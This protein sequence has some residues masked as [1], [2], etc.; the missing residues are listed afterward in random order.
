MVKKRRL[1]SWVVTSIFILL[2]AGMVGVTVGVSRSIIKSMNVDNNS[3]VLRDIADYY[4]PVNSEV[5]D[6]IK[7]PFSDEK[8]KVHINY[9]DNQSEESSQINSLIK[10]EKTY[11]PNTGILYGSESSFDILAI[12]EGEI[13]DIKD[14][15]MFGKTIEIKHKNN[16]TSKYSSLSSVN[17]SVGDTVQ[18]GE[19]IGKSGNNKIVGVSQNMLLC[20]LI[21]NGEYVNPEKY[22]NTKIKEMN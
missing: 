16:L 3:Y 18:T 21:Y 2:I 11:L 12:Y 9:Y 13:I 7:Y 20:E 19:V 17:V 22:F 5:E 14:D 15:E 10:Y 1:K 8:V 6:I 4:L